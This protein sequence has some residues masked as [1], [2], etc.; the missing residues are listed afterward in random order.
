MK[1]VHVAAALSRRSAGVFQAITNFAREEQSAGH[2]VRLIGLGDEFTAQDMPSDLGVP[3]QACNWLHPREIC[4]SSNMASILKAEATH[5]DIIHAH[6]L[7]LCPGIMARHRAQANRIPR[8][9]SVHGMLEPWACKHRSKWKKKIAWHLFEHQNLREAACLH[10]TSEKE[11]NS[12]RAL[13]L[14]NPVAIIPLGINPLPYQAPKQTP[15]VQGLLA[16][17]H[18][19][20][21]LLFLSRFHVGKGVDDLLD[22]WSQ[23]AADLPDWH[24]V[25]AGPDQEGY[26]SRMEEKSRRIGLNNRVTFMGPV[27]DADKYALFGAAELFVLPT[28]S[29]NFGLVVVEALAAGKPV[30]TTQGAPWADLVSHRCGWWVKPGADFL[31]TSMTTAMA[32]SPAA[33]SRM[34]SAGHRLICS[35]YVWPTLANRML[36]VYAWLLGN[37]EL[38][39]FVMPRLG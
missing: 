5:A 25:L 28:H 21:I 35:Q 9:V 34:G 26:R 33:L 1:I 29:E 23:L 20:R 19:K 12:I 22:A 2:D 8:V 36:E 11:A 6:G 10:A 39:D 27:Y 30:I 15:L 13:G 7:W 18:G 32:Q 14:M 16:Q 31:A 38:P 4:Y 3:F 17:T 24:L 37:H